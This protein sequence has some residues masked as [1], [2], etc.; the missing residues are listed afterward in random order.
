[1]LINSARPEQRSVSKDSS[2]KT[3]ERFDR[4]VLS[5]AACRRAQRERRTH[6]RSLRG[7]RWLH[8]SR[9]RADAWP[10]IEFFIA[11]GVKR[12]LPQ[13]AWANCST[14]KRSC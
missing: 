14:M 5:G 9:R 1:M 6:Q 10:Y 7:S 13:S 3:K 2:T 8:V 4:P 11:C 12:R